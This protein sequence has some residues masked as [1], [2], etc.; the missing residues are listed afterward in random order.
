MEFSCQNSVSIK[1]GS[2]FYKTLLLIACQQGTSCSDIAQTNLA[3]IPPV[4]LPVQTDHLPSLLK[5][6]QLRNPSLPLEKRPLKVSSF[7]SDF[8]F[9]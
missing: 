1:A 2:R 8:S 5:V 3:K 7:D 9:S 4:L 6:D